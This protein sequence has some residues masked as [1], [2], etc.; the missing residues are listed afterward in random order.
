MSY[1]YVATK[2]EQIKVAGDNVKYTEDAIFSEYN[3]Q[4]TSVEK[5]GDTVVATPTS[6]KIEF[7]TETKVPK[8]GVLFVGWGG[9]NGATVTA[10]VLA[11]KMGLEWRTKEGMHKSNYYGS[12]T[13][14][15][16]VRLGMDSNGND[17]FVP[18]NSLIPMVHPND[19]VIGGWDISKMNLGDAMRRSKVLDVN[20][21]DQLYDQMKDLV[22]MP[23]IYYPDFIAA[24]Q[25]DRADNVLKGSKKE[26]LDELIK[27][28]ND[29]KKDNGLDKVI[30]LWTANTERFSEIQEGVNDTAAN[31]LA[32]IEDDEDEVAPSTLFAVASILSGSAYINGSPQNTFVPG[33]LELAEKH[34]VYIGGDDFKSG[35]TKMKSV[36][37]DFF[38]S[39]GIK[40]VSIVSYNHLGNN[41]GKNLSAPKQFRSKE[42]SKS[43]VVDDMVASN[44][45]LFDE[46]EHPDHC[47]V[48]KYVP[49]VGD[50]KRAMD[51]Y[52]NE[53]FMG[54]KN[55]IVMH[56][57]CEDSL[58]ASPLILDL[59]ILTE[60]FQRVTFKVEGAT[61]YE[62]FHSV[63]SLLSF[64]LKAP[65]TP[66]GTPVV[67][68]LFTQREAIVNFM[69]AC[70]GL[71]SENH[72]MFD[73]RTKNP[74]YKQ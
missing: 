54:G 28:I 20:I 13:M 14:A 44:G 64:L 32:A 42:I 69:R 22:P 4:T 16:T 9:N 45:I 63:L 18:F 47:V 25:A 71:P 7:K 29:F 50:S 34:N 10:G 57:T 15:S 41:D 36:L 21:Q 23:S 26:N 31:L 49:Y 12:V 8:T 70:I 35:Q 74:T 53:I 62:G 61:E 3:Y 65:L 68:A 38:V 40:P 2:P 51:E 60:L 58:L 6:R 24:N 5:K 27:N 66:P 19:L 11:N 73:H 72:M 17:M 39:A 33:V 55:T 46:G 37:V 56:N 67:N 1:Q 30:V 48:I 59:V 52:T 43:N